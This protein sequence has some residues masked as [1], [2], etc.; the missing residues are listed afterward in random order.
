MSALAGRW[1]PYAPGGWGQARGPLDEI[2]HLVEFDAVWVV[3]HFHDSNLMLDVLDHVS[4]AHPLFF[5]N[6]LVEYFHGKGFASLGVLYQ[7][8][9]SERTFAELL[10]DLVLVNEFIPRVRLLAHRDDSRVDQVS[11]NITGPPSEVPRSL[12]DE[13]CRLF[14]EQLAVYAPQRQHVTGE[15]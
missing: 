1:T 5:E 11:G 14:Q 2:A 6:V 13:G 3:H 12:H 9:L 8:H 10:D 15:P 4:R 7:L